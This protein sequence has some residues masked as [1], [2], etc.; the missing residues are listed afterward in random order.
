MASLSAAG[1]YADPCPAKAD[2]V[3]VE[4]TNHS[5]LALNETRVC[6]RKNV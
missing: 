6:W 3:D 4:Y 2:L 1:R 5:V